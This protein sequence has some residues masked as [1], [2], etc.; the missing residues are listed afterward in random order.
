M[1]IEKEILYRYFNG[2]AGPEEEK[3]IRQ[4]IEASEENWK[5]YLRERK[6]FDTIIL[7]E[8]A[9]SVQKQ[10]GRRRMIRRIGF[11]CLKVAVVLLIAL[12]TTYFWLNRPSETESR[13]VVS[14]LKGQM[15]N[16]TLPD[17][18]RVW[19]N[20]N[21]RIEYPQNFADK[22]RDVEIDGEAYF[23]V[24]HDA[25]KPFVVHTSEKEQI[26]VLGT[27]FYVEAYSGTKEF[28]TAL[29]EGS[30]RV[31]AG[32]SQ[33]TLRPSYKA[34]LKGGKMTVEKITDFDTYRWREG[35]ICFKSKRFTE[36]LR[37]FEKYYGVGI[38]FDATKVDNPVLT[39]KF[40]LS[41]GIEYALRVLQRDVN[42]KY[43]RDDEKNT[44]TIK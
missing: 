34:V 14:T 5:E 40:R 7:K 27:R 4:Y 6:F 22:R 32:N 28:E 42:F 24:T 23:E 11:E 35:L 21:T 39:V 41:D 16:I 19:L 12:G 30:V 31:K 2:D 18:S 25:K 9:V 1:K 13:S 20:S 3:K 44:F 29:I 26:E 10:A 17:G 37:E 36:I 33:L 8:R 43:V 15:A 38:G